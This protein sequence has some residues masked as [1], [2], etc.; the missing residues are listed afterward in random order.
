MGH[1]EEKSLHW[2]TTIYNQKW[3]LECH[4]GCCAVDFIGR[5]TIAHKINERFLKTSFTTQD[6]SMSL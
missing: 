6:I 1:F 2:Q 3:T 4:S 5:N